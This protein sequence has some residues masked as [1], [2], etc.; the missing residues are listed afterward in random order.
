MLTPGSVAG[1]ALPETATQ[2]RWSQIFAGAGHI[3]SHAFFATYTVVVVHLAAVGEFGG[4]YDELL[5]LMGV[6]LFLYGVFAMP[7]GLLS[8]RWSVPGMMVVFFVGSGAAAIFCGLADSRTALWIALTLTGLFG[9]IYH[10]VGISWLARRPTGRGRAMGVNGMLGNLTVAF[11]PVLAGVLIDV[12]TW[13]AAF[14]VPGVVCVLAGLA[15]LYCIQTGRVRDASGERAFANAESSPR[16]MRQA[17]LL[18]ALL[19]V[20]TG[21]FFN[22]TFSI[23]PKFVADSI[24]ALAGGGMTSIGL[25]VA[26]IYMIGAA[27]QVLGGY[28]ADRYSEKWVYMGCWLLVVLGVLPLVAIIGPLAI[29]FAVLAVS[30]NVTSLPAENAMYA[31]FSP[32]AWRGTFYGIKFVLVYG[33][34][35]PAV[36][37]AGWFYG[38]SGNFVP[39]F[40]ALAVIAA[41]ALIVALALPRT[42]ARRVAGTAAAGVR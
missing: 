12:F 33:V 6:G 30:A 26:P 40:A 17:I 32:P 23:M 25:T 2:E 13:R 34:G 9:A 21:F 42:P 39:L 15:L 7:A 24:P 10:P 19:A 1:G 20:C 5:P 41:V 37:A 31:R 38:E 29:P 3:F 28:L 18:L 8:D 36:E 22:A 35:W 14:V 27:S 11:T 4:N 16:E